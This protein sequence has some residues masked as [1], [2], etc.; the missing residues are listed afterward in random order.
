MF[1]VIVDITV[2]KEFVERFRDA[3]VMQGK[4]SLELEPGCLGFD[5]LQGPGEPCSF[6]LCESYADE[7]A[8]KVEHRKTPHFARYAETTTTWVENK[9]AR[10]FTRIWPE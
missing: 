5:I 3:I 1:V 2:K 6:T 8:F 9:S 7:A 10:T 4:T